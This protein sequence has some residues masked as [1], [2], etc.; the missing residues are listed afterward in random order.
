MTIWD[1]VHECMPRE[2]LEQLQLE[3][4]QA[5]LN[6]VYKNV[7]FYRKKFY[8]LGIIP[9]DIQFLS[10]LT[11]LPFTTKE[12]LQSNYPYGMFA[13]PLREVVRLHSSSGTTGKPLVV[14]YTKHDI[15][16]WAN[17]VARFL[18]AAGVTHDDV[19]QI[20]FQYGLFTGGFGVH[21]GAEAIG[22]SVIPSGTGNTDKQ[23]MIMQ[24][25]KTTV[26]VCTPGY[27]LVLADRMERLGIE[28]KGLSLRVGVFGGEPWS[29][30]M[31]AE[32]EQRLSLRAMD[33]YGLSEIIGPGIAGECACKC[34]LHIFED[35]FIPEIIDPESGK[36]LP[37]GEEG[38]L[39]LTT[40]TKEAFP[41]VRYRT[42]DITSLDYGKCDCG[43]TAARMNRTMRRTDD[44]L[45]VKGVNVYPSQICEIIY[46]A[47][48][49]E[50]PYQIVLERKDALDS[51]EIRIEVTEKIFSLEM[52][53]QRAF[54][55]LVRRR[56]ESM[57][58][59]SAVVKLVEPKSLPRRNGKVDPAVVDH[60]NL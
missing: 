3:R 9:E 42:G 30:A 2:D 11:K 49:G 10:D 38:E 33:N 19:V 34:G 27:A 44:M 4:L 59:L 35:A 57:I 18:T 37:E 29:E 32:I 52:Q 13:V 12:D 14:G 47:A 28:P 43:R 55:E 46:A 5:M 7:T 25:Y 1:P 48:Q 6:R 60:R 26:L 41:L 22:A 31:R 8:E 20:A 58:G 24:D 56:I 45:I 21:Y 23:I 54:L 17:L 16:T 51:I 50:P 15:R 53:R 40:V 36:T 39:V